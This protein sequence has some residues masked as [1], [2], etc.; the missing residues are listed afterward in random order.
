MNSK[1]FEPL[2]AYLLRVSLRCFFCFLWFPNGVYELDDFPM[3]P[4]GV[5]VYFILNGAQWWRFCP[6]IFQMGVSG[7]IFQ[8]AIQDGILSI[9]I[10]YWLEG[11]VWWYCWCVKWYSTLVLTIWFVSAC[12]LTDPISTSILA[13]YVRCTL[14]TCVWVAVHLVL[15]HTT[16]QQSRPIISHNYIYVWLSIDCLVAGPMDATWW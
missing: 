2:P 13:W 6:S 1:G 11:S 7:F 5:W 16:T 3:L 8:C 10:P 4:S 9:G 12:V 14:G 15:D